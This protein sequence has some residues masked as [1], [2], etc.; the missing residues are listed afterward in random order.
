VRHDQQ[1]KEK[2]TRQVNAT[3]QPSNSNKKHKTKQV[4]VLINELQ[5]QDSSVPEDEEISPASKTAMICKLAQ[6][7]PEIWNSLSLEAKKWLLNERKRQKQED[8]KLNRSSSS[9]SR[10]ISK[11]S[12]NESSNPSS[13]S[14]MS[15][16]YAR[17][18]IQSEG[19]MKYKNIHL[20]MVSLMNFLK[21]QSRVQMCMTNKI[22]IMTLGIQNITFIQA[23][24]SIIL[25]IISV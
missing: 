14:N 23:L 11:P 10:D 5:I 15:N 19:R 2:A 20:L 21:M 9:T 6:V 7:P 17:V 13:N 22:L 4:L 12:S 8:D 1:T 18:K 3:I 25:C 16:Q 24:L